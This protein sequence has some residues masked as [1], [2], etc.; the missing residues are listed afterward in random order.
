M[1][2]VLKNPVREGC[3]FGGSGVDMRVWP[4]GS[5]ESPSGE[6]VPFGS[7]K[8]LKVLEESVVMVMEVH[9]Q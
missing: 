8:S 5:L 1:L 6:S 9:L 3:F 2:L 7:G 4:M